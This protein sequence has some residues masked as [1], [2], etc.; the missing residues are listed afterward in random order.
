MGT[1]MGTAL[2]PLK[3]GKTEGR[4]FPHLGMKSVQIFEIKGGESL[5]ITR[6]PAPQQQRPGRFQPLASKAPAS[7]AG[8]GIS[9]HG[10]QQLHSHTRL[11]CV[12]AWWL[13]ELR[14]SAYG[15]RWKLLEILGWGYLEAAG[16][17]TEASSSR[18]RE[19]GHKL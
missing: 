14:V 16:G 19:T 11:R 4:N 10:Q 8:L 3:D 17:P 12:T 18:I 2:E 15:N 1:Q 5:G 9:G 13:R 6:A 7:S